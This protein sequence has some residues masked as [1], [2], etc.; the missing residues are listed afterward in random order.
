MDVSRISGVGQQAVRR[1][2][3]YWAEHWDWECP[4]LFC[5]K[6]DELKHALHYWSPVVKENKPCMEEATLGALRELLYE[7]SSR[8]NAP[9]HE[10]I[11]ISY[12]QAEG[13]IRTLQGDW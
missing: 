11:G 13:L 4:T 12:D 1:A 3:E 10:S 5:I 6:L 8:P 2:M 7:A 9:I